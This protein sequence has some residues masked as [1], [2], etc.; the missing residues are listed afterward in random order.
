MKEMLTV[1]DN[2]ICD[3]GFEDV[4]FQANICSTGSL[5]GVLAG[6]HYN[7]CWTVHSNFA[8]AL[9]R[10]LFQ[11]LSFQAMGC[12]SVNGEAIERLQGDA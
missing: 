5:N 11:R 9:E 8:E 1:L 4:V 6:S 2:I 12:S 7:R 10:L 3:S